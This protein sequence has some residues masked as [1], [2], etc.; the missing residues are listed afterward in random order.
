MCRSMQR[1]VHMLQKLTLTQQ[2]VVEDLR[3]TDGCAWNTP[4]A[5]KNVSCG[6]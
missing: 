2:F 4:S 6:C 1:H 3:G 5:D